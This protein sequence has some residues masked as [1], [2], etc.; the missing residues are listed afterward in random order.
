MKIRCVGKKENMTRAVSVRMFSQYKN[1]KK[2][3]TLSTT[4]VLCSIVKR[5]RSESGAEYMI[6]LTFFFGLV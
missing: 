4:T 6:F 3:S 2:L 5:I 1:V